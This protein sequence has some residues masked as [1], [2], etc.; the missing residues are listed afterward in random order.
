MSPGHDNWHTDWSCQHWT[1][2]S[3]LRSRFSL[4]LHIRWNDESSPLA[5]MNHDRGNQDP[6]I[7]HATGGWSP[8]GLCSPSLNLEC[9]TYQLMVSKHSFQET[10]STFVSD[11]LNKN[12]QV[13]TNFSVPDRVPLEIPHKFLTMLLTFGSLDQFLTAVSKGLKT[14]VNN[15][16]EIDINRVFN[17]W[18]KNSLGRHRF[19]HSFIP[20]QKFTIPCTTSCQMLQIHWFSSLD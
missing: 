9:N 15:K 8:A 5:P 11:C 3:L 20:S 1:L 16:L 4:P 7:L 19:R 14:N 2:L 6:I 10:P 18:V 12:Q 13:R 17:S